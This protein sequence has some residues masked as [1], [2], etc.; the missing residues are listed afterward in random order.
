MG[1]STDA[2]LAYGFDLGEDLSEHGDLA[3]IEDEFDGDDGDFFASLVG[4]HPYGHPDRQS[5]E[6]RQRLLKTLPVELIRHCSGDYPMWFLAI[7]GTKQEANRG[8]P[9]R[10]LPQ[11]MIIS[12]YDN[13]RFL[14][15]CREHRI[16]VDGTG[17]YIMSDWG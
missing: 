8:S 7:P 6:E 1:Q 2:I 4:I 17:W 11:G 16:D 10:V 3:R 13:R 14:Q 5:L 15:W 9:T 12:E